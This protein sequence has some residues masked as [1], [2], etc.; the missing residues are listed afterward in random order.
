MKLSHKLA[1]VSVAALMGMSPVVGVAV[2]NA[3]AVQA[4]T[5]YKTYGKNSKITA[6]KTMYFVDA[7]GKKTSK[8]A[9]EGGK[10]IIWL[11]KKI[12]G[13]TYYGIQTDGKYWIP[14]SATKGKVSYSTKKTTKKADSASKKATKKT[15]SSKK[16]TT[17]KTSKKTTSSTKKVTSL[18]PVKMVAIRATRVYDQNGK[19]AKTYKGSKKY[20]IL[21]KNVKFDGLGTK[22][23]KGV[24]YVALEPNRF[25]VKASDVKER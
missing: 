17:K 22:T 7:N 4:A 25:Y 12:N 23:I 9:Y 15:T 16:S 19:L 18:K 5:V 3:N 2:N 1:M 20:T 24:K 14:A 11:V 13:K 6:T 10:Y 8:K 21:G